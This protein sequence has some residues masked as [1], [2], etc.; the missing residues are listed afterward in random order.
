MFLCPEACGI[1]CIQ[2][3]CPIHTNCG[4]AIYILPPRSIDASEA[5]KLPGVVDVVT[6]KDVPGKNGTEDEQ[7]YA[8]DEVLLA[9]G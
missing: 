8:E 9:S 1:I 2:Y 5:L 3:I 4:T 7:A 6:A